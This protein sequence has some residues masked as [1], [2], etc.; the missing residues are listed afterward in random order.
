MDFRSS[1]QNSLVCIFINSFNPYTNIISGVYFT[2]GSVNPARSFGPSVV[3][4]QFHSYHWIYWVGPIL[5]SLLASGFYKFIKMLEYE[6]ANPG[7]DRAKPKG[8]HFDPDIDEEIPQHAHFADNEYA[9][10]EGCAGSPK[11]YGG[12]QRPW[13]ESPA[14]PH[15]NDMF[16]GL[17]E[18]GMH[19]DEYVKSRGQQER[20]SDNAQ[21][22]AD[23][24]VVPKELE[25]LRKQQQVVRKPAMKPGSRGSETAGAGKERSARH[26]TK[27]NR[28]MNAGIPRDEEFY[29]KE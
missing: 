12:E 6:T 27:T 8:E 20:S 14:P 13:S 19:G 21:F 26:N 4:H 16:T 10:E 22:P 23:R 7:Q 1:S 17:V 11:E 25:H 2:G 28:N 29:D 9:M 24:V 15:P 3:S 5:G 18:G